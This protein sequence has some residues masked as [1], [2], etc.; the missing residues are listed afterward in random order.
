MAGVLVAI[1]TLPEFIRSRRSCVKVTVTTAEREVV[2][3]ANN[4]KD[5]MPI[6]DR[7]VDD[8]LSHS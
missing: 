4:V 1:R 6:L 5:V 3:E 8:Q 7:M 2:L